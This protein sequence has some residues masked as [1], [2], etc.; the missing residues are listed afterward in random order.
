MSPKPRE[1]RYIRRQVDDL[2]AACRFAEDTFGL[3][4]EDRT[5]TEAYFRADRRFYSLC[6]TTELPSAVGFSVPHE[7]DLNTFRESFEAAGHS[8]SMLEGEDAARRG[9]KC[10][11]AVVAPNGITLELIWRHLESGRPYHGSRDTGLCGFSAV[12]LAATDAQADA[13]F[14]Q[15]AGLAVSDY[16]GEATFLGLG[17]E[18]HQVAV[19]PSSRDGLLGAIWQVDHVDN[20]MRHWHTLLDRQVMIAHGPGRQPTSGAAFLTAATPDGF[21]MS[22]ATRM[23]PPPAGGPRQFRD[24]AKSHCAWGSPSAIAEFKGEAA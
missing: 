11:L 7:N 10:G 24:E 8:V 20:V 13:G 22:Y 4:A 21:L 18:H 19:Y 2:G 1:L 6:L 17:D 15:A 3:M 5:E 14:W 16:A 12:Q 9:I 23:D